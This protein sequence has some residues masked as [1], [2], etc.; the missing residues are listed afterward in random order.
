MSCNNQVIIITFVN[1]LLNTHLECNEKV[2]ACCSENV[3]WP[4][5]SDIQGG[6]KQPIRLLA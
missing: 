5:C 3:P 4:I 6:C 2:S 1:A